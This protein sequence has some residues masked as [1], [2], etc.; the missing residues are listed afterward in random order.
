MLSEKLKA[1][2]VIPWSFFVFFRCTFSVASR[3]K[4]LREDYC[5]VASRPHHPVPV[6]NLVQQAWVN[7]RSLTRCP[8][9]QSGCPAAMSLALSSGGWVI[10]KQL[11][12]LLIKPGDLV[13][14]IVIR[15]GIIRYRLLRDIFGECCLHTGIIALRSELALPS[16]S[17]TTFKENHAGQSPRQPFPR[18]PFG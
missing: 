14:N 18:Q 1:P 10:F 3:K 8:C 5:P 9:C 6:L 11:C 15:F 7:A 16:N 17:P 13:E 4:L 2:E 12:C